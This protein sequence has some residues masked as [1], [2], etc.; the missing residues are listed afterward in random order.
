MRIHYEDDPITGLNT[1]DT[2]FGIVEGSCAKGVFLRLDNGTL[3]GEEAFA[4][5]SHLIEGDRVL[6]TVLRQPMG[7]GRKMLVSIDSVQKY[8]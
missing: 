1:F 7:D 4:Y 5:Y 2:C 3:D 8:A 6:C